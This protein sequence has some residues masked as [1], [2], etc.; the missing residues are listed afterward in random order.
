MERYNCPCCGYPTL[1]EP[2]SWDI[3]YLCDWED[4][5][6][7][8]YNADQ[9]KGGPNG[10][11]SLTEA[12]RNFKKYYIMYRHHESK[13][14]DDPQDIAKVVSLKQMLMKKMDQLNNV[15]DTEDRWN[16]IIL[17]EDRLAMLVHEQMERRSRN[18]EQNH[19]AIQMIQSNDPEQIVNG[20]LAL[21][22][23]AHDGAFAQ[24]YMLQYSQH[25]NENVRGIAIL[26]LGHIARIHGTLDQARVLPI[27]EKALQDTS[28]FVRGHADSAIDDISHFLK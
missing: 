28:E 23:N 20:L 5:G 13:L 10:D 19:K 6:Q 8:D 17:L 15:S 25:D 3:C 21:S 12:R 2:K 9:I 16:R 18:I 7:D 26:G 11:Y 1:D 27:I 14:P 24:Q 22:M 4:D